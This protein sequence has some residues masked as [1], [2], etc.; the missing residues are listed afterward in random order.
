MER[1]RQL[2]GTSGRRC[3]GRLFLH[4]VGHILIAP[5]LHLGHDGGERF[6]KIGQRILHPAHVAKAAASADVLSGGRLILGV[7]SGDRPEDYPALDIPFPERGARFRASFDYISRMW[8]DAPM[9]RLA[10][11]ILPDF[12]A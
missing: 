1:P 7:A 2:R 5:C 11:D 9:K 4:F 8:E 10:D 3:I 12:S 6:P